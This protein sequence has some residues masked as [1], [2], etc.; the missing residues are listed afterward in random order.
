MQAYVASRSG[1]ATTAAAGESLMFLVH[2]SLQYISSTNSVHGNHLDS[3][4]TVCE[5]LRVVCVDVS[6]LQAKFISLE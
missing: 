4:F 5:S 3:L 1:L 2:E 6:I